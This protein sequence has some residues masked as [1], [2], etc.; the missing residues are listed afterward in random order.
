VRRTKKGNGSGELFLNRR[1]VLS[2]N[3]VGAEAKIYVVRDAKRGHDSGAL[4]V[5][6]ED[7]LSTLERINYVA[8]CDGYTVST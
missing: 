7:V 3:E 6:N 8:Q 4:R 1:L 5:E 2:G